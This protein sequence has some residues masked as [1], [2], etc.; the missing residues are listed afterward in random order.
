MEKKFRLLRA[1]I[2]KSQKIV[3]DIIIKHHQADLCLLCGSEVEITREHVIP[4]WAFEAAP[5]KELLS[6]KNNQYTSYIKTTIPACRSCNS[7]LLGVFE[8]YLKRMLLNKKPESIS[9]PD[10]DIIIWWLQYLGFKLQVMDLRNRFLRYRGGEYIPYLAQIP[11][12]MFWGDIDT[13]PN[14]VF[15][16]IR[17]SRRNLTSKWKDAK[18][19]SLMIFKSKN[20]GFS[21]FHK[22]NEFIF[23]QMPQ[24][25]IAFFF[26]FDKEFEKHEQAHAECMQIIKYVWENDEKS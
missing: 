6:T 24:M 2:K 16:T 25:K 15:R 22:V 26:F 5:D 8:D 4:Q 10:Y 20:E 13:T 21:F 9:G 18:H 3:M 11:V 17:K 19:N 23:I 12:A 1:R 7:E 14:K